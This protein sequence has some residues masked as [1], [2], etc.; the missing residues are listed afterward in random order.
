MTALRFSL[1]LSY[2]I[3]LPFGNVAPLKSTQS[4][5]ALD[6][7]VVCSCKRQFQIQPD[8]GNEYGSIFHDCASLGLDV[9]SVVYIIQS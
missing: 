3:G 5:D 9:T 4:P 2:V 6:H 1:K 8:T 7:I